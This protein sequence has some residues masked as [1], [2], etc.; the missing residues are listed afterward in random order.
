MCVFVIL[1][2][3]GKWPVVL[4]GLNFSGHSSPLLL[5][6][7]KS[8]SVYTAE[9]LQHI[10]EFAW[11]VLK[12]HKFANIEKP[13][14]TNPTFSCLKSVSRWMR[15]AVKILEDF[16]EGIQ[17]YHKWSHKEHIQGIQEFKIITNKAVKNTFCL[18]IYNSRLKPIILT[19]MIEKHYSII[20]YCM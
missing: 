11:C 1:Y 9:Q 19:E 5:L 12:L 18:D 17:D 15:C 16:T 6:Q 7:N 13:A 14:L 8:S 20:A 10:C 3:H 4:A 2:Y